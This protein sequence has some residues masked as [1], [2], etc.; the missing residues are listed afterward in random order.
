[1]RQVVGFGGMWFGGPHEVVQ[2]DVEQ[3]RAQND[4]LIAVAS[5]Y[6]KMLPI[7][8]VHPY[9]GQAALDELKRVAGRGV[10]V[11]KL[12][13]HTQKFDVA[14]PRVLELVQQ[15]GALGVVVLMTTPTSSPATANTCSIW[16]SAHKSASTN[17]EGGGLLCSG[18]EGDSER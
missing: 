8:T 6:P 4:G 14:D 17:G 13:P 11:L 9:D 3:T 12:H 5:T 15:A 18:C 16:R 2:G 1:K 10:K 7:A